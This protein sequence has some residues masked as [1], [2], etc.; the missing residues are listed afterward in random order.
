[1]VGATIKP[2]RQMTVQPANGRI[3]EEPTIDAQL[4]IIG[5]VQIEEHR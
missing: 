3:S 2:T 5:A 4:D 1:V